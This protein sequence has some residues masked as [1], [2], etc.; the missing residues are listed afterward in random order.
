MLR[1]CEK[2]SFRC[3]QEK[4]SRDAFGLDAASL[5]PISAYCLAETGFCLMRPFHIFML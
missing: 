1:L 2:R 3:L 4:P 5:S